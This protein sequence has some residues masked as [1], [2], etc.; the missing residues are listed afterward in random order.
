MDRKSYLNISGLHQV[1]KHIL[2]PDDYNIRK[3]I[4]AFP[5]SRNRKSVGK[6]IKGYPKEIVSVGDHIRAKRL[7]HKLWQEEVAKILQV[8]TDTV[9]NWET[10]R[11]APNIKYYPAIIEFLGYIPFNFDLSTIANKLKYYRFLNGL[12][13]AEMGKLLKRDAS[14]IA[15]WEKGESVPSW[16]KSII[17]NFVD[18]D[19][20]N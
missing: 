3:G 1:R 16:G 17:E 9:T 2:Y 8:S 10:G 12:S 20:K 5:F 4:P 13:H 6:P 7:S 18:L 11:S 19:G 14:T 15:S